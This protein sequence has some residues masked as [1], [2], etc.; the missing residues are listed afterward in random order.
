MKATEQYFLVVLFI[1]MLYK[2]VLTFKSVDE[3]LQCNPSNES[4][5][6]VLLR[7]T[8]YYVVNGVFNFWDFGQIIQYD[9]S[10]ETPLFC[11]VKLEIFLELQGVQNL[12]LK[13]NRA[14]LKF[15]ECFLSGELRKVALEKQW[16]PTNNK[17]TVDRYLVYCIHLHAQWQSIPQIMKT[18]SL[19]LH[20]NVLKCHLIFSWPILFKHFGYL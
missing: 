15:I 19:W 17:N 3:I 14:L 4:Y 20:I 10:N 8:A 6:A 11:S 13:L 18:F 5:W 16:S 1:I 9:Q 12:R 7:G 2:V